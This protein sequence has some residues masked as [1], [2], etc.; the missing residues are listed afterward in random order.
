M[1]GAITTA[2]RIRMARPV[3]IALAVLAALTAGAAAAPKA[4]PEAGR[5]TIEY[6]L[7]FVGLPVGTASLTAERSGDRYALDLD[8]G[9]RGLAG[10]FVD[11]AGTASSKGRLSRTGTVPAEFRLDT[12]YSGVPIREVMRLDDGTVRS[13]TLEPAAPPR[14]DRVPV[15]AKDKAGVTDPVGMLAIP[16]GPVPLTPELCDR[17][18]PVYDGSSRSDLVLSRG[19]LVQLDKGPFV[20]TA[21][22][23]RVR[24]VPVS[25]HRPGRPAVR[26][27]ADN[28]DMRVRLAPVPGGG[29]LLP[30]TIAVA[31]GWGEARIQA[32][33][34][35]E[36]AVQGQA[37]QEP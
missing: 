17:R 36:P 12:R 29:L 3:P 26:R 9:L 4:V 27:M 14:P 20:G 25:G 34:W 19:A 18:I 21:L 32:T 28:D 24:W 13:V 5:V 10:M 15:T 31:T 22:E 7:T 35:G 1:L 2:T 16:V 11:G 37:R 33:R 30:L 8:A 23:C 6:A